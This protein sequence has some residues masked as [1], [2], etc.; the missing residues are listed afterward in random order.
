VVTQL[1][2]SDGARQGLANRAQ[3][4]ARERFSATRMADEYCKVYER[5]CL[6]ERVA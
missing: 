1:S 6:R 2:Q 4:R 5:V 3:R